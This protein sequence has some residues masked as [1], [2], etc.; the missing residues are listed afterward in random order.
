MDHPKYRNELKYIIS[1][2]QFELLR[3]RIRFIMQPDLHAASGIYTVRSLYFDDCMDRCFYENMNGTDPREK[4][5]IRIYNASPELV[6]L[7]CKRKEKGMTLKTSCRLTPQQSAA[8]IHKDPLN[9][10]NVPPLLSKMDLQIRTRLLR[11][12]IIVEYERIPFVFRNG[13]VRVTFDLNIA[14]SSNVSGFLSPKIS[15]RPIMPPGM[16]LLEV[17]FNEFLPDPIYRALNL[18]TLQQT[19]FSKYYLCRRYSIRGF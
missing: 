7:E 13:G 17:K 16:H 14:S 10:D 1:Q 9:C 3:S 11:P 8:L 6:M 15:K 4:F 18:G 2:G 12:V 5:R 19:A